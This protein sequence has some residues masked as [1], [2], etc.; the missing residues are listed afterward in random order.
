MTHYLL[1]NGKFS[2]NDSPLLQADNRGF[3]YGDGLFET[4]R[5][6]HGAVL[7]GQFHMDRLFNGL[8][9]LQFDIPA[10]FTSA[11][12]MEQVKRLCEKNRQSTA[13]VRL[14]VFRG[15]GGLYDPENHFPNTII[16]SW[17]LPH[18]HYALNENGL[19]LGV[20]PDA[21]KSADLFSHLKSNNYLP[22]YMAALFAKQQ[23]WNDALI[24]NNNGNICDATIAN[25]FLV[26]NKKI[27]TPALS[28][29]G[30]SGVMRRYLLES[31]PSEGYTI[32]ETKIT[33]N[34]ILAADELF[35]SNAI[36]GIQWVQRVE[37]KSYNN[38]EC[39]NIYNN[40]LKKML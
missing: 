39:I 25:V 1:F 11:T 24:L 2:P 30:V 32:E 26:K 29:G 13:R 35:L 21:R 10:L 14:T 7:L 38:R 18:D 22:Y 19:V 34:D 15:N 5:W 31:L 17:P 36:R 37:E 33:R 23:R 27:S 9:Q 4:M 3:R 12:V 20:Y 40:L 6:S 8:R 16:Q 28:E